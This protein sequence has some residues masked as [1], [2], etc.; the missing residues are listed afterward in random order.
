M[1][2]AVRPDASRRH[3]YQCRENDPEGQARIAALREGLQK[4]GWIEGKTIHIDYRWASSGAEILMYAAELVALKPELIFAAPSS[5]VAAVQRATRDIPV[6]FAQ[7]SDP[8]GAG[9]VASL[10]RPAGNMTGFA[11]FEFG[12]WSEMAGAAQGNRAGSGTRSRTLRSRKSNIDRIPAPDGRS[13]ALLW[14]TD[15]SD[16]G[17]GRRGR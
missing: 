4:L 2:A 17:A 5:A 11:L 13:R 8:V 9:F 12:L 6:V 1:S 14:R 7:V 16:F 10:P 15:F 3:A